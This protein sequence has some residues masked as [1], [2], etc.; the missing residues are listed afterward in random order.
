[1]AFTLETERLQLREFTLADAPY[2]LRQ[3]N[4]PSFIENIADR[5]V[6]TLEQAEAYLQKGAIASYQQTGFGFWAVI[7]KTT[8]QIIIVQI[9]GIRKLQSVIVQNFGNRKLIQADCAT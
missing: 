6:R 1:M 4:E 8:G 3:L 7:E 2:M 5:G 9:S